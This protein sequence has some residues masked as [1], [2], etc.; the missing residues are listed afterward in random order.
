M[1][2]RVKLTL[3]STLLHLSMLQ[4]NVVSPIFK[5]MSPLRRLK[6]IFQ[7]TS[8]IFFYYVFLFFYT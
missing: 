7:T 1:K 5:N 6:M 4:R 3:P 8:T 2:M